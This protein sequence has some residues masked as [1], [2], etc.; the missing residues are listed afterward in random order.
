MQQTS[1]V[2]LSCSLAMT[3]TSSCFVADWKPPDS[4]PEH[5]TLPRAGHSDLAMSRF[6]TRM[7]EC[8][9]GSSRRP[10]DMR[11]RDS[12]GRSRPEHPVLSPAMRVD[13]V[14]VGLP[15]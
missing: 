7:A 1:L 9:H 6:D 3:L 4:E 8:L 13:R 12:R 14:F 11:N 10:I 5:P 2:D 15:A